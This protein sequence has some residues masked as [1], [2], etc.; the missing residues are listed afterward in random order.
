MS[1]P[2]EI[3]TEAR[4]ENLGGLREFAVRACLGCGGDQK[5][6]G[7][8]ELAVDEAL[9][10]IVLHGYEGR[11]PGPIVMTVAC[12]EGE[13]VVTIAD[14]GLSFSPVNAPPPDL[15]A[16]WEDRRI[17]GLGAHLIRTAMDEVQYDSD[18]QT[19]NT[20][21]LRKQL[22]PKAPPDGKAG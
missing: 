15:E 22:K 10:N 19:G 9:T 13:L 17:G 3:R 8:V 21:T 6:C 20:L 16:D 11:P 4:L 7:L 12:D 2:L 14:F 18:P 1:Q 5:T